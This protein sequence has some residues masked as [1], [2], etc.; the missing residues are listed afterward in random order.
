MS[1]LSQKAHRYIYPWLV[2]SLLEIAETNGMDMTELLAQSRLA[3]NL[4]NS[5]EKIIP[6]NKLLKLFEIIQ[7]SIPDAAIFA[8]RSI[9]VSGLYLQIFVS[10]MCQTFKDYLN[11]M[12]SILK[13][14]GDIGEVQL[15]ISSDN[16]VRLIWLPLDKSTCSSRLL[17]DTVMSTSAH[18]IN[19]LCVLPIPIK[20]A[21]F[22]YK[23]PQNTEGLKS[24]FGE[25][26]LFDSEYTSICFDRYS[27]DYKISRQNYPL[28]QNTEVV[29]D[30]IFDGKDLSDGFWSM[31][32]QSVVNRLPDNSATLNNIAF[33]MNISNRSLQRQLQKRNSSFSSE[34][35]KIRQSLAKR[36]LENER[37][38][39]TEIAYAL[40]YVD[41]SSFSS[42]FRK[43][44]GC[45]PREWRN[46]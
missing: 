39:S 42:A 1:C 36:Y 30:T 14:W 15:E 26:L 41:S 35:L 21:S 37:W 32:R 25:N 19:N 3:P 23:K 5:S 16:T 11:Q 13:V 20:S 22:T 17:S 24:V 29:F 7:V 34:L 44:F 6:L 4:I 33:D 27:L 10:S 2:K 46:T 43:W 18:I 9:F 38:T 31:F 40:G 8:G 28:Q 45:S 12:P